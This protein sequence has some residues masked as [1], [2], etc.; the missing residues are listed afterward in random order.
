MTGSQM[1]HQGHVNSSDQSHSN[2]NLQRDT[3]SS[4]QARNRFFHSND[5]TENNNNIISSKAI[6]INNVNEK[7]STTSS[8]KLNPAQKDM[9]ILGL[10]IS[11]Y[12]STIQFIILMFGL[13]LFMCLYGYFQELVIY[14]WFNRKL[15]I[16]STF[17]HFLGCSIFAMIQRRY[18]THNH[19]NTTT[20][21]YQVN[22][23]GTLS[24]SNSPVNKVHNSHNKSSKWTISM[25]TAPPRVALGYYILQ[26]VIKTLTQGCANLSM[27]QINYPAKVN[28]MCMYMLIT[29]MYMSLYTI[30]RH[31]V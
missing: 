17:M 5:S 27:S 10:D 28:T 30:I 18:F 22:D 6:E 9:K 16:F 26:I 3:P 24:G 25:G 23:T 19:T 14:G 20:F 21:P 11:H 13:L 31:C 1:D 7:L 29:S 8:E 2:Y 4:T 12:S 15:S